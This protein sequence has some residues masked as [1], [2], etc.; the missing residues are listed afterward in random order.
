MPDGNLKLF[1]AVVALPI[2][3][4]RTPR[5]SLAFTATVLR[6]VDPVDLNPKRRTA[7]RAC[8]ID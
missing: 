2:T 1:T 3:K 4:R 5:Q 8:A 6:F 7:L